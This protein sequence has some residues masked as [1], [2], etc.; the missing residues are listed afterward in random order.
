MKNF[1][2]LAGNTGDLI[3]FENDIENLLDILIGA[4]RVIKVSDQDYMGEARFGLSRLHA[5]GID[6][7]HVSRFIEAFPGDTV[8]LKAVLESKALS[9]R[10]VIN[11]LR[12]NRFEPFLCE[13]AITSY[14]DDDLASALLKEVEDYSPQILRILSRNCKIPGLKIASAIRSGL[15]PRICRTACQEAVEMIHAI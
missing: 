11:I 5:R 6:D 4:V 9:T 10:G 7:S 2:R 12:K 8:I 14:A 3:V 15:D 13:T 1:E